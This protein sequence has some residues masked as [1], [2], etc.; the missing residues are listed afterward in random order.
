MTTIVTQN[1]ILLRHDPYGETH[2]YIPLPY[3]RSPRDPFSGRQV[4]LNIE[5]GSAS[6]IES[7]WCEWYETGS[8]QLHRVD[9]VK[10]STGETLVH[11][12]AVLPAF[13][14]GEEINYHFC[15]ASGDQTVK[16]E[17]FSF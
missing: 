4:A 14:G 13:K 15:A 1:T 10:T 2:P 3:E 7:L 9:A 6:A 8:S 17:N 11:W 16:A 12:Q 5:T